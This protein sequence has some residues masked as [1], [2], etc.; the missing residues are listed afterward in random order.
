MLSLQAK[1]VVFNND[2]GGDTDRAK[3]KPMPKKKK[4]AD[5]EEQESEKP[6]VSE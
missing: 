5:E 3:S 6:V 4:E 2:D 1:Y